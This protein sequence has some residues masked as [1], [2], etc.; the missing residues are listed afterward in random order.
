MD[1]NEKK[2]KVRAR[3]PQ[4]VEIMLAPAAPVS[5][6]PVRQDTVRVYSM[7]VLT[8]VRV[9]YVGTYHLYFFYFLIT[10]RIF[11][12]SRPVSNANV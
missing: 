2:K 11:R 10:S 12:T 8:P 7:L 3:P 6:T 4:N 5:S 1:R 9:L